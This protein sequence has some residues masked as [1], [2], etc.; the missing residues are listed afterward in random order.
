MTLSL[1]LHWLVRQR[2]V[3]VA[4]ISALGPTPHRDRHG[5]GRR[6]CRVWSCA[7]RID[8]RRIAAI[9]LAVECALEPATVRALEAMPAQAVFT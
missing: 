6:V 9:A 7:T 3:P 4:R 2:A 1:V 8:K 5:R